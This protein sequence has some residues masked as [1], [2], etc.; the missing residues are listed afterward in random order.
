VG[1]ADCRPEYACAATDALGTSG[2]CIPRC[3]SDSDCVNPT[4]NTCRI[5]DGVCVPRQ[6]VAAQ[7]GDGCTSDTDCGAGQN[8]RITD[9][10]S[11]VKQCT[12]I[13]A[14]NGSFIKLG[15]YGLVIS[16]VCLLYQTMVLVIS[17]YGY[18][19]W[20]KSNVLITPAVR[21]ILD[22]VHFATQIN[23][24]T[25]FRGKKRLTNA[26]TYTIWQE[27]TEVVRIG[28]RLKDKDKPIGKVF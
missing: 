7:I 14:E 4:V 11:T 2:V 5:C 18:M 6:N 20:L 8:C 24:S 19:P 3:Y 16:I 9:A 27:F 13:V 25:I 10:T 1:L 15:F 26:A 23:S 12:S 22:K 28:E 17:F 21:F